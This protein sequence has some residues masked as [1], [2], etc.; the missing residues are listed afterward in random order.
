MVAGVF[1]L[2]LSAV[3]ARGPHH[4]TATVSHDHPRPSANKK[5]LDDEDLLHDTQ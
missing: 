3:E 1:L 4:P 2:I 5:F